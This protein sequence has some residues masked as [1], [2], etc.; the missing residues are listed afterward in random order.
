MAVDGLFFRA[1]AKLSSKVLMRWSRLP[2]LGSVSAI[3]SGIVTYL[4][5]V[6][7]TVAMEFLKMGGS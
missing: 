7:G 6:V 1:P 2:V 4:V 3:V 5:F